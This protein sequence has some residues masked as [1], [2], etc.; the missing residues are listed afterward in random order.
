MRS[1]IITETVHRG[2]AEN[3]IHEPHVSNLINHIMVRDRIIS[4][5]ADNVHMFYGIRVK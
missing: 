3:K 4:T 1:F 5:T 2:K